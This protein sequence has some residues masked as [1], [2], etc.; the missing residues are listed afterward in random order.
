VYVVWWCN[1]GHFRNRGQ[2][3][4]DSGQLTLNNRC[5]SG[6]VY[7]HVFEFCVDVLTTFLRMHLIAIS[8]YCVH[9][10]D[11]SRLNVLFYTKGNCFELS[12]NVHLQNCSVIGFTCIWAWIQCPGIF[13]TSETF[14]F[15]EL[16]IKKQVYILTMYYMCEFVCLTAYNW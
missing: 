12:E 16:H 6:S 2:R 11:L 3:T 5:P 10:G 14:G 8:V 4:A 13:V 15:I 7:K 1:T 9:Q